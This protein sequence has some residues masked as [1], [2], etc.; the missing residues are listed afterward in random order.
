MH[1]GQRRCWPA[2]NHGLALH[3]GVAL[4]PPLG[5]GGICDHAFVLRTDLAGQVFAELDG[6]LTGAGIGPPV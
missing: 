5:S 3:E 2:K 4:Y 6:V 1:G